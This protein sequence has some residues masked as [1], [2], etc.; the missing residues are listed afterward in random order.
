MHV[1]AVIRRQPSCFWS[2]ET[3]RFPRITV[4][5][6]RHGRAITCTSL[7]ATLTHRCSWQCLSNWRSSVCRSWE[8]GTVLCSERSR[9]RWWSDQVDALCSFYQSLQMNTWVLSEN[10]PRHCYCNCSQTSQII[11]KTLC[12]ILPDQT[13]SGCWFYRDVLYMYW[14]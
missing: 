4:G 3:R 5:Y 14:L 10:R 9:V 1:R 8:S 6:F 2:S 13:V 7:L 12:I 11:S